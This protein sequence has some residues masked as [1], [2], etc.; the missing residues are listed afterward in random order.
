[1]NLHEQL[2]DI[3][4]RLRGGDGAPEI[5][6]LLGPREQA[7]RVTLEAVDLVENGVG[8]GQTPGLRRYRERPGEVGPEVTAD[9]FLR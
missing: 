5:P 2:D 8:L 7:V 6:F 9:R 3:E 4:G 1:M